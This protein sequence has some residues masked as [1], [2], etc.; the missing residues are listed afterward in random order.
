MTNTEC[1]MM[2]SWLYNKNLTII[3]ELKKVV[4]KYYYYI[5]INMKD[6]KML[7]ELLAEM[8][9]SNLEATVYIWLLAH[10][11]STGYNI[12][13]QIGKPVANTYKALKS[14]KRKGAVISDSTSNKLIYDTVPIDQFLNSIQLDFD[15]KRNRIIQEV[16][17]LD[18]QQEPVGIYELQSSELVY[19]KAI[20]M[21]EN[22]KYSLIIDAFPTPLKILTPHILSHNKQG[23]DIFLKHYADENIPGVRQIPKTESD[24]VLDELLGQWLIIIKDAN[25]TLIAFFDRSGEEMI[26][27]VWIQDAFI[28]LVQ[29]SGSI[30][31]CALS[32]IMKAVYEVEGTT[33]EDIKKII[34]SYQKIFSYFNTAENNLFGSK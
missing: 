24:I 5:R 27:C 21:I 1:P 15:R 2:K 6:Q 30:L 22:A 16:E 14:L 20:T 17:K 12:A 23:L 29:F 4:A 32:E 33:I 7:A 28:S 9:L 11:R 26:H 19:E 13:M 3:I 31:E 10:K 8:G 18:V 25:E 34:K